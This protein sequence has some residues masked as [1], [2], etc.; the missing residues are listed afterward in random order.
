MGSSGVK[1]VKP[2]KYF[3]DILLKKSFN[4]NYVNAVGYFKEKIKLEFSLKNCSS[5][6][7]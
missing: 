3:N 2:T 1:V 5:K 7:K 6:T 4:I